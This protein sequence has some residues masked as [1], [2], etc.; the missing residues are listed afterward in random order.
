MILSNLSSTTNNLVVLNI[1][2]KKSFKTGKIF[3]SPESGDGIVLAS[4]KA[5]LI[6]QDPNAGSLGL[7]IK[8][9]DVPKDARP[10]DHSPLDSY[11]RFA[12]KAVAKA[13]A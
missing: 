8:I 6:Y 10:D 2:P 1:M 3:F 4:G 5:L 12:L 7:S 11:T 9:A 13:I